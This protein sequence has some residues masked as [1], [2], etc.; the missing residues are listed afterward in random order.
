MFSLLCG[1]LL[2]R[3]KTEMQEPDEG[4]I[5]GKRWLVTPTKKEN[6]RLNMCFRKEIVKCWRIV[7]KNPFCIMYCL[8]CN[9]KFLYAYFFS[10]IKLMTF[11]NKVSFL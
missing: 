10:S 9:L 3:A 6:D 4:G 2:G 1:D 5:S 7:R 8:G 11:Q